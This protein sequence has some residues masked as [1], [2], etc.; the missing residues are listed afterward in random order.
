VLLN[1]IYE[2]CIYGKYICVHFYPS[3]HKSSRFLDLIHSNVFGPVK[4][5]LTSKALYHVP[6]ISD[7][8]TRAWI[9]VSRTNIDNFI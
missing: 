4:V 1:L 2:P 5:P 6:F 8:S 3:F 9:Y 7:Y